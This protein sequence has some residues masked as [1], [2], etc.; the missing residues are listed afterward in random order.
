MQL[1]RDRR[2]KVVSFDG[3]ETMRVPG[4]VKVIQVANV[5][6]PPSARLPSGGVAVTADSR[7]TTMQGRAALKIQW[8][9]GRH[10]SRESKS[11]RTALETSARQPE[12]L[13]RSEG[14]AEAAFGKASKSG[15]L[16]STPRPCHDGATISDCSDRRREMRGLDERPKSVGGTSSS[17]KV[18]GVSSGESARNCTRECHR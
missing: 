6:I 12:K 17:G 15:I 4:V 2:F 10:E 9:H 8:D 11:Y 14:E 7:W 1:S 16:H 18:L 3:S 13:L 5:P